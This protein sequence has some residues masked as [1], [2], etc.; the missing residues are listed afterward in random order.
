MRWTIKGAVSRPQGESVLGVARTLYLIAAT[1]SLVLVLGGL[2][3]ALFFQ[4]EKWSGADKIPVPPAYVN[5]GPSLNINEVEKFLSPPKN[6]Q[7]FSLLP[8]I[9]HP[10]DNKDRG[11]LGQFNA[12]TPNGLAASPKDFDII[13]GKDASLFDLER[14]FSRRN[15][16]KYSAIRASKKLIA[17]VNEMLPSLQERKTI[18]YELK[19]IARDRLGNVSIPETITFSLTYAPPPPKKTEAAASAMPAEKAVA[20]LSELQVLARDI[21]LAVDPDK[22]PSY[23]DA[24]RRAQEIPGRCGTSDGDTVF[25]SNFRKS[26]DQLRP[27]LTAANIDAF[28]TGICS[29]WHS[30]ISN[31]KAEQ[32]Q[33]EIARASAIARNQQA[34]IRAEME[35]ISKR[36]TTLSVIGIAFGAFLTIALSLAL[37]AIE[38][39]T[40][41]IRGSI[42]EF[43][44]SSSQKRESSEPGVSA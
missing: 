5:S 28:Y 12:D 34:E 22:T 31:Q 26:F 36:N 15:G 29:E 20:K 37:L 18:A 30:T 23:F 32:Q 6:I 35:A 44:K 3:F 14:G 4:V 11:L 42:E 38:N 13:G 24:Y 16:E 25:M 9:T 21:A 7:F 19:V 41:A 17:Q 1:I 40:R 33:I 27:K 8:I 43:S 10:L 2:V 39:H